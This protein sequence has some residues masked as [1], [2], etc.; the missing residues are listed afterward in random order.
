MR[1]HAETFPLLVYVPPKQYDAAA[2][3]LMAELFRPFHLRG[4]RYTLLAA[5]RKDAVVPGAA[6]RKLIYDWIDS[7]EVRAYASKLCV[8]SAAV[9]DS[10]LMR[11]AL[12][13]LL[14]FWK[15]PFPLEPVATP[16]AGTDFCMGRL[17]DARIPLPTTPADLKGQV[18][19][20]VD[21]ID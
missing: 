6:E 13:A 15:P 19:K 18:L 9:V 7:P 14:W 5:Q 10:V 1:I 4:E 20:L 17:L 12:T 11:G 2:V 16:A 3:R 8:G 21:A